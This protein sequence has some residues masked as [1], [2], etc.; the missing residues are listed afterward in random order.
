MSRKCNR[1]MRE[2]LQIESR[3]SRWSVA[4]CGPSRAA[5]AAKTTHGGV[6]R[7]SILRPGTGRGPSRVGQLW[8]RTTPR[9]FVGNFAMSFCLAGL[10]LTLE[11]AQPTNSLPALPRPMV[12]TNA[13]VKTNAPGMLTRPTRTNSA[14]NPRSLATTNAIPAKSSS[15]NQ[16]SSLKERFHR[17]QTIRAFYPAVVGVAVCLLLGLLFWSRR[18]SKKK[19][20]ALASSIVSRASMKIYR[21]KAGAVKVHACNVLEIG[22]ESRQVWQF[23]TRGSNFVLSREHTALDGDRLPSRLVAKNWRS[24]FQRKLNIAWLPPEHVFLRVASFPKS[25]FDETLSMV[26]L[27]LEKL[28][29]MPVAQ[30]VWSIQV[31]PHAQGNLQTVIL[32][33]VSRNVV[34]EFLGKLEGQGYLAD[35][36]EL[37]MLDQLQATAITE[38]GAWIYP[39]AA[40]GRNT[41]LVAWWY[42]GVLQN[43]DLLMLPATNQGASLKE[44]LTQMAWAG[45]LEGWLSAP[46]DWHL[47]AD[48]VSA[49]EWEPMLRQGLEQPVDVTTPLATRDLASLTARRSAHSDPRANLMPPDF[50]VRYQQQFVDRLWMGGLLALAGVYA[51]GVAIY[52]VALGVVNYQT[53]G[54][55]TQVAQ[56]GGTYTN[57]L[58]L[59]ARYQVLKDRQELKYAGLDCWNVTARNLPEGVT[60]ETMTFNQGKRLALHGSAQADSISALNDFDNAMRKTVLNQQPFF[61]ANKG[62]TLDYRVQGDKAT[63]SLSYEL[64]RSE[65]Q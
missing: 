10:L 9:K 5:A 50:T 33:I 65:V 27:Q 36:L 48:G 2:P 4:D 35:R 26:E 52:M 51:V 38:D 57:A 40:G 46:P 59:K 21:P 53:T 17:L 39:E 55:E 58:Q 8:V 54:V 42:G 29:P 43:L 37:P 16:V 30:I 19:K 44:Q 64:K 61:D 25:D 15:T 13:P 14:A 12:R 62:E 24:L 3:K 47:V 6:P 49:G 32:M 1:A 56:L 20:Q 45:E 31:L 22:A 60:L 41:A 28:S 34:E 18:S 7:E 11:A 63:W 23:E